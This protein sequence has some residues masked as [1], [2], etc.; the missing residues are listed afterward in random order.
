MTMIV[1]LRGVLSEKIVDG[2]RQPTVPFVGT[3]GVHMGVGLYLPDNKEWEF[4]GLGMPHFVIH[5]WRAM[6]VLERIESV[7][8]G[9]LCGCW[10]TAE[11]SYIAPQCTRIMKELGSKDQFD[12]LRMEVLASVPT[13][14][15]VTAM[16]NTFRNKDVR[17]DYFEICDEVKAG[18][19]KGSLPL[20]VFR[21]EF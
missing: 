4:W 21:Q 16:V 5:S 12:T 15:E 8:T 3:N 13:A 20:I 19:L 14:E 2:K 6:K 1:A 10:Y 7:T 11:K 18:R 9:T 17:I